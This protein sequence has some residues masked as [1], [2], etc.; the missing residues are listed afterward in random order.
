LASAL[1]PS[2]QAVKLFV[3]FGMF[4]SLIPIFLLGIQFTSFEAAVG[5]KMVSDCYLEC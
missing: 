5:A 2:A 4:N 3:A 1:Q